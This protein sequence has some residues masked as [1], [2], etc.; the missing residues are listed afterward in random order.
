MTHVEHH[1][2]TT[3]AAEHAQPFADAIGMLGSGPL[4]HAALRTHIDPLFSRVLQRDEVYLA[5][6]SLGR[7]PDRMAEDVRL[8]L[9]LWYTDMDA[10]WEGW[11]EEQSLYRANMARL[12]GCANADAVVPKTSAGQGLRAVLNALPA[13]KPVVVTTRAEFDSIDFILKTYAAKGLIELRWVDGDAEGRVDGSRVAEAVTA[14]VDLV[15]LS[16]V[17][18]VTGQIVPG[19]DAVVSAAR[20]HGAVVVLDTYHSAGVIDVGFDRLGVDF[21]IGGNY[22]YTRG[23]PGACWLAIHDRHLHEPRTPTSGEVAPI[24]TGWFAKVEPLGFDRSEAPILAGGGDGW[25][26]ATPPILTYYQA[27]SGLAFAL[28]LGVDRTRV[29]NQRQQAMLAGALR[30][31]GVEPRLFEPRGAFLLVEHADAPGLSAELARRGVKTDARRCNV[32]G[33][34]FVRFCPDVLTTDEEIERASVI[35]GDAA[36]AV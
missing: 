1:P 9:D 33:R 7:P 18:F 6:H 16:Q 36:R 2:V 11:L 32:T 21:A 4:T 34:G 10:A 24:D 15:V 25:L 31:A 23:G 27:K 3:H 13:A 30:G 28:T 35:V 26:E 8:A 19:V 5:N 12:I 29:Y 22:K 17:V 14:D 20:S